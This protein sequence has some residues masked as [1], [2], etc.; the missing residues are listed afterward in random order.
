MKNLIKL[1]SNRAIIIGLLI[2][3]QLGLLFA[4]IFRF[5]E[6][7][8]YFYTTY[9]IVSAAVIIK[10]VNSRTNPAYKIAWIIP[11][12]LI[13]IFGTV[14]YLV[15]GR[16]RFTKED[17][18][19]MS[20]IHEKEMA[21][22]QETVKQIQIEDGNQDA[23]IQSSYLTHYGEGALFKNTTSQYFPVG[24]TAFK[25]M[26][27]ELEK[28]EKYIFMEYFIVEEGKMWDAILEVLVRKVNEG[29]DVR[30]IYDDFG[31][32]YTLPHHYYRKLENYGI[33]SCVFNPFVPVLS[34]IFNNRNHR[35]ITV[36]DGKVAFTG[37]INLA[38]EY[39]NEVDRFGHWKD[40][41]IMVKGEAAWGFTLL[42]LSLWEF[43][44]ND[45]DQLS[46]FYP[47]YKEELPKSEGYYQP[48]VDSPF[49][50]ETVGM[51][52]YLNLINRAKK[53]VY[54]TTPYLIIDNLLMEALCTS[55]KSGVDIRIIVPHQPDKWYVHAVT[56]SNYS[57]L[58]EAGVKIYEYTPGFIH[59]KTFVVDEIYATVGTVN[60]DYRSLFLHFECGIWMYKTSSVTEVYDDHMQTEASSQLI[61][62]EEANDISWPTRMVRA[63]LAVFS[64]LL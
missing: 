57:Q 49:D 60:L 12:M 39:I 8:V 36:I 21:L 62:L 19:K 46:D 53:S 38:D 5:Q 40:N 37:G 16:I 42:F 10:I 51:N 29:L 34:S 35:K 33:K 30:V 59:S 31:C 45:D 28:A 2:L 43:I 27:Q 61:T 52:V 18:R 23:V 26:L 22:M 54:I 41:S 64:P 7:F 48:Y 1:V 14:I 11:I 20:Q 9:I 58:I 15:F 56:K 6:Y 63:L 13:P 3:L 47:E 24:E 44:Y 55:A 25:A 50:N 32:L 4:I 17:K